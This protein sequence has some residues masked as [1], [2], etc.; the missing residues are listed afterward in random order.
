MPVSY[1]LQMP[2]SVVQPALEALIGVRIGCK[3]PKTGVGF[4]WT[5]SGGS[6]AL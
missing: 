6:N 3:R 2:V 1:E 4:A 5:Q